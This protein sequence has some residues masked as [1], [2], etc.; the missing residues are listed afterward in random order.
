[1]QRFS[2]LVFLGMRNLNTFTPSEL[3]PRVPVDKAGIVIMHWGVMFSHKR[4]EGPIHGGSGDGKPVVC[5]QHHSENLKGSIC[6]LISLF[7]W[8][9]SDHL[10]DVIE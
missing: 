8:C 9:S 5:C 3:L 6:F 10:R 1:M 2:F 7:N 4:W